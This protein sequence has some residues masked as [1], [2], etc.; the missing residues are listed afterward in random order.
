ML[1]S[2]FSTASMNKYLST[3][4]K[5]LLKLVA[6]ARAVTFGVMVAIYSAVYR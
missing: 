4:I 6:I 2:Y 1:Q 5:Q 3:A